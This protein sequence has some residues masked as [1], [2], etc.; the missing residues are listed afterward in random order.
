MT[1]SYDAPRHADRVLGVPRTRHPFRIRNRLP[2]P[3][4][5]RGAG[6]RSPPSIESASLSPSIRSYK[7]DP[8][9]TLCPPPLDP[10]G[11]PPLLLE[12]GPPL[13][14]LGSTAALP[15]IVLA[16]SGSGF[17]ALLRASLLYSRRARLVSLVKSPE[18]KQR[19][20]S[21]LDR[22]EALTGSA[23][24]LKV[25]CD[26]VFMALLLAVLTE[27]E[28]LN[29]QPLALTLAIAV[30]ALL[31]VTE[32]VP[33]ALARRYGDQFL[34]RVLPTFR[35][36]QLPL[37]AF[38]TPL[39]AVSR[40]ILRVTGLPQAA[41]DTREI[42]EGFREVIVDTARHGDLDE[43]ERELIENVMEFRDVDVAEIMTPRTEIHGVD[44][45]D[46]LEEMIRVA[47]EE[48][49]SR[50]PVYE[51]NLD[52]IIGYASARGIVQLLSAG[53]LETA[54]TREHLQPLYFVPETKL[55]SELLG[56]FRREHRKMAIVLDEYGGTAGLVTLGDVLGEIVGDIGD[57]Y[58]VPEPEPIHFVSPGVAEIE[59]NLRVAEV[60]EA[61]EIELPEEEDY[62]TLG[63]FVLSELGHLPKV[64]E[65]FHHENV[66]Y[67]VI[68]AS[69]R[70]VV[71]VR[72]RK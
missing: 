58:D 4:P 47:A 50:I 49:H 29:W 24:L 11:P 63:G 56:E 1:V 21:L 12:P 28:G 61:L 18:R 52:N 59:A 43:A 26:L 19:L 6:I 36:L 25:V 34:V 53:D 15:W 10:L 27:R 2:P 69:D 65:T 32:S 5:Q 42:V 40:A 48:G 37:Q 67:E 46:G 13:I 55:V 7:R 14:E 54:D 3:S 51:E 45:E 38:V 17:C 39:N 20:E 66:G 31:L 41:P 60:N 62:E 57:E 8:S 68:E 23:G 35:I 70:R 33:N 16:L 22:V 64:G 71:R 44:I 30:P 72:V 9:V